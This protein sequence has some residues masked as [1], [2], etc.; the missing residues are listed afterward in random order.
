MIDQRARARTTGFTG[1]KRNIAIFP[2]TWLHACDRKKQDFL[3]FTLALRFSLNW[4]K[5]F[6]LLFLFWLFFLMA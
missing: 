5:V 2:L 6:I 4:S 1:F 3:A